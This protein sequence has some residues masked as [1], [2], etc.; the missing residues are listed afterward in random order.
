MKIKRNQKFGEFIPLFSL[1]DIMM[2]VLLFFILTSG[3]SQEKN[4]PFINIKHKT[5]IQDKNIK[6]LEIEIDK[7]GNL[8]IENKKVLKN[9]L[10]D[11]L[12]KSGCNNVLMKVDRLVPIVFVVDVMNISAELGLSTSLKAS[13]K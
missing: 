2:T 5:I 4:E 6:S 1:A 11:I 8:M 3:A 7:E 13:K 12:K 10:K 9:Q